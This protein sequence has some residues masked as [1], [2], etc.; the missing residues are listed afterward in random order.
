[1][2][3]AVQFKDKVS[4][5]K[6]KNAKVK[7]DKLIFFLFLWKKCL[8]SSNRH[9]GHAVLDNAQWTSI[10]RIILTKDKTKFRTQ[11]KHAIGE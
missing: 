8:R 6:R 4:K 5:P 2:Q 11:R 3:K 1:M 10:T 9:K 7:K